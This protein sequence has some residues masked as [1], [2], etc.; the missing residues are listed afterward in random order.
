MSDPS[1]E[2]NASLRAKHLGD[3]LTLQHH[4]GSTRAFSNGSQLSNPGP[5]P[6]DHQLFMDSLPQEIIDGI[7]DTV[8][9]SSLRS[10]SLVAKR[11]RKRS[12]QRAFGFGD[13]QFSSES[14]SEVN[15][16]FADIQSDP[17]GISSCVKYAS[18]FDIKWSDP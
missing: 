16:W 3:R 8:P 17:N 1:I 9:H 6:C 5:I 11:W 4:L 10:C 15:R 2:G 18:F 12:Q 14:E 13:T 7:I